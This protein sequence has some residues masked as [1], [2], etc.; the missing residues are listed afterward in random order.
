[1]GNFGRSDR[2]NRGNFGR[3][4]SGRGFNRDRGDRSNMHHAV[5]DACKKDC[6]VP[7]RPTGD[8]PI[9]CSD[10]FSKQGGGNSRPNK[11]GS[12]RDRRPRFEKSAGPDHSKEILKEIKTLNYRIDQLIKTLD[13]KEDKP[14]EE[15]KEAPA[16]KKVATKKT[17]KK[18]V[19]KKKKK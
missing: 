11:F 12:D 9:F 15:K 10:C 17:T 14:T 8:K 18:K 19:A 2:S 3:R 13:P 1:M 6:E 5:C 4:D 7:F 16:E